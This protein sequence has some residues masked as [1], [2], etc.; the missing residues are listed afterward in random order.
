MHLILK[1]DSSRERMNRL[2]FYSETFEFLPLSS[3]FHIH[4]FQLSIMPPDY[5]CELVVT[6]FLNYSIY[7]RTKFAEGF[8]K[9][10]GLSSLLGTSI[11]IYKFEVGQRMYVTD[12]LELYMSL[13]DHEW[14]FSV[15]SQS[16]QF[17]VSLKYNYIFR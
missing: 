7:E 10:V 13:L 2:I 12:V 17:I 6:D 16:S 9:H 1:N 8:I 15:W 5:Q 3:F 4:L 11:Q 14:E